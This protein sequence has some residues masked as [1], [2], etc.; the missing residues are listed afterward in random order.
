M[1]TIQIGLKMVQNVSVLV[2]ILQQKRD[3]EIIVTNI[4]FFFYTLRLL[5]LAKV[6]T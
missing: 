6:G 4:F 2:R 3:L 1:E 5:L